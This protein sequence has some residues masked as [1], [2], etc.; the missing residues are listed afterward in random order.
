MNQKKNHL[1]LSIFLGLLLATGCLGF[2]FLTTAYFADHELYTKITDPVKTF[3]ANTLE[4]LSLTVVDVQ[5]KTVESMEETTTFLSERAQQSQENMT[6]YFEALKPEPEPEETPDTQ[7]LGE[8]L[9]EIPNG[10]A[11]YSVTHL[12]Y[13]EDQQSELITGGTHEVIYYNQTD[14]QWG[15]YGYDSINGYGCG[16]TSM[17]MIVSTLT[18][19]IYTPDEMA[20]IF[21]EEE[22][23]CYGSGTYYSFADG[24]GERFQLTVES[25]QPETTTASDLKQHLMSGKLAIALMGPGHFTS[26][27]HYIVLRGTTLTGD[28]LVADPASRDRSLTT[29]SPELI[30]EELSW[31]RT[32]GAPIWLFSLKEEENLDEESMLVSGM[33]MTY[34][35]FSLD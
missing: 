31:V 9:F 10:L 24:S 19:R 16:P 5:Q 25:L 2:A 33:D 30:L 34:P 14:P 21:V 35:E 4:K 22:F 18:D 20:D 7:A 26:G 29:W 23:W 13:L 1:G 27:G 15:N 8:A 17:A 28:I 6:L 3:T 12:T 11:E 32:S